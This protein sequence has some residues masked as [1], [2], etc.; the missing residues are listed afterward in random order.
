MLLHYIFDAANQGSHSR[1]IGFGNLDAKFLAQ[2]D[3]EIQK[4]HRVNIE[5]FAEADLRLNERQICRRR[6]PAVDA[7][8]GIFNLVF[9]HNFSGS[10]NNRSTAARNIPPLREA[11]ISDRTVFAHPPDGRLVTERARGM[12]INRF[13]RDVETSAA[14]QTVEFTSRLFPGESRPRLLLIQQVRRDPAPRR[15]FDD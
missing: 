10:C 15:R 13:V 12:A 1:V 3:G 4:V 9:S 5:L 6:N 11:E 7:Q 2:P 14:R 8:D